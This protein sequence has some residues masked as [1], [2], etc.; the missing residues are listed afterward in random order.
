MSEKA[1]IK[2]AIVLMHF[3]YGGGEKMVALLASRLD[4][5]KYEV[6][7]YCVYG[8][9]H[10]NAMERAVLESGI[11]IIYIGKGLGFSLKCSFKLFRELMKFS[12]DIVHTHLGA[13][14][15]C[16][17]WALLH[18]GRMLHTLHSIPEKEAGRLRRRVMG[19]LFKAE[20]VVPV[21]ISETNRRLTA[22]F[23][24]L[25]IDR[26]EMV[27]NPVDISVFRDMDPKPFEG[28]KY[29]FI[30]VARFE[31]AKNHRGLV[32]A[33]AMFLESD[34]EAFSGMR[35]ALVGTGPLEGEIKLAVDELGLRNSVDFLGVRDDVASLMHDSSCFV[36]PSFYEGLPMTI[37]EAMAA[38]IP[39]I[40]TPVGGVPDVVKDGETG[41]LVPLNDP[42]ALSEAMRAVIM[43]R[44]NND[45]MVASALDSLEL[46]S[47][48]VVADSYGSLYEKYSEA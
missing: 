23:Y 39:I 7:V 37:L 46:Y 28:R 9:P 33:F 15:Y 30:H 22:S 42:D 3:N 43:N 10:D 2:I 45:R 38:G 48:D 47:C 26:V 18:G 34:R 35:M 5:A 16:A 19:F 1:R 17:P 13:G 8:E 24:G 36:L 27:V 29:A 6:K 44:E 25:P 31:E 20:K 14:L 4:S 32:R 40:A 11:P 21:A 41:I 12:P